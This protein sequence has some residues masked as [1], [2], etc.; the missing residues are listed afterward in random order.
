M[1]IG[2][3][4]G[5]FERLAQYQRSHCG[6]NPQPSLS[7]MRAFILRVGSDRPI[8]PGSGQPVAP[9]WCVSGGT[10]R[11]GSIGSETE[12]ESGG[13]IRRFVG[14]RQGG[15]GPVV[16]RELVAP[17]GRESWRSRWDLRSPQGFSLHAD[18]W[19]GPQQRQ[20]LERLC[21]YITHPASCRRLLLLN[22]GSGRVL[23]DM[24][25]IPSTPAL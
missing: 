23:H 12:P 13:G 16:A 7:D 10:G 1:G 19:C 22:L 2:I 15:P 5:L 21:R 11:R 3:S 24:A 6:F 25:L 9:L 14:T 18:T 4:K 8:F 17:G 20:K